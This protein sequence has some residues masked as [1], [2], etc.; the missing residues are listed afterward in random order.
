MPG[1]SWF[2]KIIFLGN[3]INSDWVVPRIH[4]DVKDRWH[5]SWVPAE[6]DWKVTWDR[7]TL[8]GD[9]KEKIVEWKISLVFKKFEFGETS[10]QQNF[11]LIAF[12][13]G[14]TIIKQSDIKYARRPENCKIVFGIDPAFSQKTNTD[15]MGFVMTAHHRSKFE[16]RILVQKYVFWYISFEGRDKDE[17]TF[18][19]RV[20]ELYVKFKCSL[21]RIEQQAGWEIIGNMLKKE[22][23][24]VEIIHAEK[25]KV[26]RLREYEGAFNRWEIFFDPKMSD[27][28]E[29]QLLAF[30]NVEH[31]DLVDALVYSLGE[32]KIRF[33]ME[34]I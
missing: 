26:T 18:K 14:Q 27:W 31:D 5:V 28:L 25:D 33:I 22:G 2:G 11:L 23:M 24:A 29:R 20:K 8:K 4:K 1:M 16:D 10:Y 6:K 3:I 15:A 9:W 34:E 12:Q 21:I 17:E 13:D 19:R 30:P 32:P 7:Y